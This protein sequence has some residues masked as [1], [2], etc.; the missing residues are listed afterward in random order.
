MKS[1]QSYSGTLGGCQLIES[2]VPL[3]DSTEQQ[4]PTWQ[5]SHTQKGFEPMIS[6]FKRP[7][8]TCVLK[9]KIRE[10]ISMA[11]YKAC[12]VVM[13]EITLTL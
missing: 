7:K 9:C 10:L 11:T 5:K 8:T 2:L 13:T 3:K 4:R 12:D 1:I 6:V